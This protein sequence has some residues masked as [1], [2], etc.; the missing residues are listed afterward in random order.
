MAEAPSSPRHRDGSRTDHAPRSNFRQSRAADAQPGMQDAHRDHLILFSYVQLT[1]H[2]FPGQNTRFVPD[3]TFID[4]PLVYTSVDPFRLSAVSSGIHFGHST[5]QGSSIQS[6]SPSVHSSLRPGN[7][8]IFGRLE[9]ILVFL[10]YTFPQ[11]LY[12]HFLF[13]LPAFYFTRVAQIFEEA[14]MTMSEIKQMAADHRTSH[15]FLEPSPYGFSTQTPRSN[16]ARLTQLRTTWAAFI[17][18]LLREWKT[19]NIVSVLLLSC[20]LPLN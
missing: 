10:F 4:Q 11:Q 19:L 3:V 13:R 1:A 9:P 16:L 15:A 5:P 17:D 7:I 12:L 18:S 8:Y 2:P 20:V 14:E 6:I